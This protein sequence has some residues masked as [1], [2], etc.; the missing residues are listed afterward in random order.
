MNWV[1]VVLGKRGGRGRMCG[2]VSQDEAKGGCGDKTQ[3]RKH[4]REENTSLS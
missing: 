3:L 1:Q 4:E 2:Q